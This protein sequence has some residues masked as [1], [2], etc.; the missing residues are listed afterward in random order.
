MK[1]VPSLRIEFI[2]DNNVENLLSP[3]TP[4]VSLGAAASST[5]PQGRQKRRRIGGLPIE[6]LINHDTDDKSVPGLQQN[7]GFHSSEALTLANSFPS[8]FVEPWSRAAQLS[9]TQGK[10]YQWSLPPLKLPSATTLH[11]GEQVLGAKK[12][13][14][15]MR[16]SNSP[17]GS[18]SN[19]KRAR[20]EYDNP[21]STLP[22]FRDLLQSLHDKENGSENDGNRNGL[23]LRESTDSGNLWSNPA[24]SGEVE[25]E[26]EV[27]DNA[28]I[29][30]RNSQHRRGRPNGDKRPRPF[31]C[32]TCLTSFHHKSGLESHIRV[33]HLK[34]RRYVCP[35]GCTLRF[36]ARGDVTRHVDAVHLKKRDW[37][38]S[39]C[40]AAFSRKSILDRHRKNVHR[41]AA[42]GYTSQHSNDN[43]SR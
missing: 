12:L 17:S 32:A 41:A 3:V 10:P 31:S 4:A 15:D 30:K 8:S 23:F 26:A 5:Y 1:K 14:L 7:K 2:K 27:T 36:G 19:R 18:Y 43:R 20:A 40:E 37:I 24:A 33:V 22:S 11:E 6:D 16:V 42:D 28:N 13:R 21:H 39:V 25:Y 29:K 35:L 38:C 34:E 9:E